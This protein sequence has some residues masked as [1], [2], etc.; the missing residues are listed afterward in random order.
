MQHSDTNDAGLDNLQPVEDA[1]G[2]AAFVEAIDD[3]ALAK[4]LLELALCIMVSL[5][6]ALWY[7][8]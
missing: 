5:A 3:D 2:L 7:R 1:P 4:A 8:D 6:L